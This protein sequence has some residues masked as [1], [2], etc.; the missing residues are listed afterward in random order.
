FQQRDLV[1]VEPDLGDL[2]GELRLPR[3]VVPPS[4]LVDHEVADVVA[5]ARVFTAGVAETDDEQVERRPL[6][7]GPQ[8]H[9]ASLSPRLRSDRRRH[10]PPPAPLRPWQPRPRRPRLRPPRPL[11]PRPP[12]PLPPQ[13]HVSAQ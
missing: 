7:A 4:E 13:W 5:M 11:Q 2:P 8:P 1:S 10:P 12:R 6:T 3:A 9:R